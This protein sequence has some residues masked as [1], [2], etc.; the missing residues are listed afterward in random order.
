MGA[1][2]FYFVQ[3]VRGLDPY[4]KYTH[5]CMIVISVVCLFESFLT[6]VCGLTVIVKCFQIKID[7]LTW[8]QDLEESCSQSP[9]LAENYAKP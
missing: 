6:S 3:S 8:W 9:C 5:A 2:L 7:F 1:G 4:L